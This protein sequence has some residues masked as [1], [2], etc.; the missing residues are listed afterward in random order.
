M[1]HTL[2]A[3]DMFPQCQFESA[4]FYS[5]IT[6]LLQ[7]RSL[8]PLRVP[9]LTRTPRDACARQVCKGIRQGRKGICI[10]AGDI[11]P[12]D[13]ISHMAFYCEEQGVNYM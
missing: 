10:I 1:G 2:S 8:F 4:A 11:S 3:S 5:K 7:F 13:V 6:L 12:I 9:F